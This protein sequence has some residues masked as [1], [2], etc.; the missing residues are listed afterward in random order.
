MKRLPI[1]DPFIFLFVFLLMAC[2]GSQQDNNTVEIPPEADVGWKP[3][4]LTGGYP[5]G[6]IVAINEDSMTVDEIIPRERL[7]KFASDKDAL[8]TV[9][10]EHPK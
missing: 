9:K 4:P 2:A 8:D 6:S 5:P 10:R 1:Y 3:F 7:S